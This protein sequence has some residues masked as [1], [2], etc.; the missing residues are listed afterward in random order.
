[1]SSGGV[2]SAERD[3]RRRADLREFLVAKRAGISPQEAGLPA[4]GRRRTPGLRREEVAVLAGVGVSWY[5]WLEQGRDITVSPSVLDAVG[6]ALRLND[7]E[8][9]HLYGLAGLNPPLTAT[10]GA[11]VGEHLLRLLESWMPNPAHIMDRYWNLV[12][13]NDAA[14]VLFDLGPEDHNALVVCFSNN[15][16]DYENHEQV[17]REVLAQFRASMSDHPGDAGFTAVV[18][19]LSGLSPEF[20]RLW[21]QQQVKTPGVVPKRIRHQRAGLLD[22]EASQLQIPDRPDLHLVYHNPVPGSDT[23][24]KMRRLLASARP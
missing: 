3:E 20:A 23:D 10:T 14:R 4:G 15:A 5:Q 12:A 11:P 21:S 6:R 17:V 13:Y 19:E 1:M 2:G 16:F 18:Q 9:R 22:Y 8:R 24:E 7:A